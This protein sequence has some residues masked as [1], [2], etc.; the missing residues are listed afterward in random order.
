MKFHEIIEKYGRMRNHL[1]NLSRLLN[2]PNPSETENQIKQY[3]G[4]F[5][6]SATRSQKQQWIDSI[7]G[8]SICQLM[9]SPNRTQCVLF[10]LHGK[11][12]KYYQIYYLINMINRIILI[13]KEYRESEADIYMD[14][15][16][17]VFQYFKE[18][19]ALIYSQTEQ[20]QQCV[21]AVYHVC[22]FFETFHEKRNPKADHEI[23][24]N[25]SA[26]LS[27]PDKFW[28]QSRPK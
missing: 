24:A 5:E 1:L 10:A 28:N 16:D 26:I 19:H 18:G 4:D 17:G 9:E 21:E 27:G 20:D 23:R 22:K 2:V 11:I 13:I 6:N 7:A 3:K 8:R 25:I 12:R 14:D 15:T